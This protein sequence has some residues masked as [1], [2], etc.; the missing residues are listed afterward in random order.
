VVAVPFEKV[1]G[2]Q[3]SHSATY[4]A[5]SADSLLL[6]LSFLEMAEILP[7]QKDVFHFLTKGFLP[8]KN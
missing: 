6:V 8:L 5:L 3:D 7:L 2:G 4:F 1:L